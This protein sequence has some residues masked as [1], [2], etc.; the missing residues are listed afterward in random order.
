M[1]S[2]TPFYLQ[3]ALKEYEKLKD[4]Q[5]CRIGFRDNLI[6]FTL[7]SIGGLYSFSINEPKNAVAMLALPYF[8]FILGWVYL[9]NDEKITSIGDYLGKV[10]SK[11][12]K[13]F[14]KEETEEIWEWEEFHRNKGERNIRKKIQLLTNELLFSVSGIIS[15]C[16]FFILGQSANA[17]QILVSIAGCGLS[18]LIGWQIYNYSDHE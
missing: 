18:L 4:E 10:L 13:E 1:D 8:T 9:L 17:F 3:A 15:I 16:I 5:R 14:E 6:Y 2:E 7:L 11:R 12:I